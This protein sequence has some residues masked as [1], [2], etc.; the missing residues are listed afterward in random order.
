MIKWRYKLEYHGKAL[1]ETI[2]TGG[3]DLESCKKTLLALKDCYDQIKS[4][5]KA[6]WWEFES[7]YNTLNFYIEA[8]NNPDEGKREDA[9]LDGGY[10]GYN[11]ALDCVNDSLKTFYDLCDYHR[12]WVGV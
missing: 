8:L 12:I 10:D 9:L 2:N 1:R 11:P 7:D 6:D 4:L 3:D 5:V